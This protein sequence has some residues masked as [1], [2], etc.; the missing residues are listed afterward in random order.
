[1][2]ETLRTLSVVLSIIG[3][4]AIIGNSI[5][6]SAAII[7][8]SIKT[9]EADTQTKIIS[10]LVKMLKEK[11][12]AQPKE[13]QPTARMPEVAG[14]KKVEGVG[15]GTNPSKGNDNA[16]VLMVEFS[17]FQC[18]FT[19]RF[20]QQT[21]PQIEKEYIETG[22]VKFAY[23][24]LALAFHPMAK[25]AAIVARCAGKQGKYWQMFDKLLTGNSLDKETFKKYAQELGLDIKAFEDCQENPEIKEAV[26]ADIKDAEKFGAEGTPSFFINGRFV[27]GAYPFDIFK[28]I[29][30]EE[31]TK[32][33]EIK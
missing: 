31:L 7:A 8:S 25:P 14:S 33:I 27:G 17:D 16:H 29:I 9:K 15:V 18:P 22:K 1:M 6:Q 32:P 24:D 26:E 30:D 10:E 20:F 21:F 28:K 13:V 4:S 11:D 12:L 2:K 23:R 3:A 19:K 5:N